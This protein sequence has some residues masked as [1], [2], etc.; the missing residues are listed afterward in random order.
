MAWLLALLVLS[1]PAFA[2]KKWPI[3]S[4]TVEGLKNYSPSQVLAATGLKVGQ[5][6]GKDDFDA[7]RDRLLASGVFETAGYR[8]SPAAGSSG[9]AASFQVVEV[10]PVLPVRFEGVNAP[11]AE[12]TAATRGSTPPV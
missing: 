9:H 1:A 2:Q 10:E 8:F 12:I 6:A 5:L 7:A 3:E 4:L 11:E